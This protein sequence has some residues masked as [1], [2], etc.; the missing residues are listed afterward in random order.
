MVVNADTFSLGCTPVINLF[1]KVAEPVRVDQ[2]QMEYR[3]MPDV[4]RE[5]T[6]EI[7]SIDSVKSGDGTKYDP[8]FSYNHFSENEKRKAFWTSRVNETAR[9]DLS[10]TETYISFVDLDFKIQQPPDQVVTVRTL[11]TNRRLAEHIPVGAV[12]MIEEAA[13][14]S[15]I[16][17]LTKP[18]P[19]ITSDVGGSS[20]W[21]L[22]SHLSLNHLSLTEGAESLK[23]LKE[24]LKLYNFSE[25]NSINRQ[26]IGINDMRCKK[27][28][29]RVGIEAWRGMC[30][31]Y[32]ITLTF[33]DGYYVGS[34]A[35][36]LAS[37]LNY[38]FALYVSLNSFSQVVIESIQKEGVW[39]KWPPMT[40]EKI[41][42]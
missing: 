14:L 18:T 8:Y 36:L 41:V 22:I 15:S 28:V 33:D 29:R 10:G 12:F 9:A 4:H 21:K 16:S 1:S 20:L 11:C 13:P 2:K 31:G 25:R 40:G 6:T 17:L 32:E 34:S 27:V 38:F 23:A 37:V 26:I 24:I 19:Q 3:I 42:L 35:I 5:K 30:R 39:K 7:Y